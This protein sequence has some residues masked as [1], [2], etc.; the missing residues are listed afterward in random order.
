[1]S[2]NSSSVTPMTT[3][4]SAPTAPRVGLR[5][6]LLIIAGFETLLGVSEFS[7]AFDLHDAPLSLGQFL[8]NAK[9]AVHPFFATAALVLAGTGRVRGAIIALAAYILVAW[10]AELQPIPKFGIE[11]DFSPVGLSIFA[12]QAIF[13]PLAIAT[14][15]CGWLRSLSPCRRQ[16]C[17]SAS[18][19]SQSASSFTGSNAEPLCFGPYFL[20]DSLGE[21]VFAC[22]VRRVRGVPCEKRSHLCLCKKIIKKVLPKLRR[23]FRGKWPKQKRKSAMRPLRPR[24]SS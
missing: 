24:A 23:R 16:I 17:Y 2:S 3:A 11:W 21:G 8:M 20:L 5:I 10:P 4:T 1:M 18:S 7:G 13:P 14:G 22:Q 19:F 12:E 6:A 9:L 15:I